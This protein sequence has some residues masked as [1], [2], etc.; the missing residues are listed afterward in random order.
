MSFVRLPVSSVGL[1]LLLAF[2][3]MQAG[4]GWLGDSGPSSEEVWGISESEYRDGFDEDI[5][6]RQ[7]PV[8]R[9]EINRI[10]ADGAWAVGATKESQDPLAAYNF[11]LEERKWDQ[12]RLDYILVKVRYIVAQLQGRQFTP[13]EARF[14]A[15]LNPT[16][17]EV[18]V[19][20]G[21]LDELVQLLQHFPQ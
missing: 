19:V 6:K 4:C 1:V 9:T 17:Q 12:D 21:K 8:T 5:L 3:L 14:Y 7:Q 11:L 15:A 2:S 20:N 13:G 18:G 16:P 10:L